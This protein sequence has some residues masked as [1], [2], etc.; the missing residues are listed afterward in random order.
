MLN[1]VQLLSEEAAWYLLRQAMSKSSEKVIY[2]PTSWPVGRKHVRKSNKA[3]EKENIEED[4]CDIWLD[5][6]FDK[7]QKRPQ[8]LNDITLA[9]AVAHYIVSK[10]NVWKQRMYPRIV[11][12]RSYDVTA[13]INEYK[14]EMV[15]L[16][17]AFRDE[18]NEILAERK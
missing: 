15:T 9:Q 6:C 5:N 12:Y 3:L 16:H 2:I 10:A 7:Y 18:E 17:L 4:S 8:E 13:D 1:C 14:R 11:R